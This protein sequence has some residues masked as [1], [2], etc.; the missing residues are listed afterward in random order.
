MEIRAGKRTLISV[1]SNTGPVLLTPGLVLLLLSGCPAAA[2]AAAAAAAVL[3][4]KKKNDKNKKKH[5]F[6]SCVVCYLSVL[7]PTFYFTTCPCALFSM[8]AHL[9]RDVHFTAAVAPPSKAQCDQR[10][11]FFVVGPR[12]VSSTIFLT[13]YV[14]APLYPYIEVLTTYQS[15]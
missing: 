12:S 10:P 1:F 11:N 14:P 5:G 7:Y 9:H 15:P 13:T 6:R 3:Q 8:S 2:A 4:K